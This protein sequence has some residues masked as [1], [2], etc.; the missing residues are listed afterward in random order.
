VEHASFAMVC[1]PQ[2][3]TIFMIHGRTLAGGQDGHC[4]FG[5]DLEGMFRF[6]I[7]EDMFDNLIA[8]CQPALSFAK[9]TH[10]VKNPPLVAEVDERALQ[11]GGTNWTLKGVVTSIL[12]LPGEI[13]P[14]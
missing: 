7:G 8:E 12:R 5:S 13:A 2:L 3:G 10:A 6:E 9:R 4:C 11:Q 14:G 1:C